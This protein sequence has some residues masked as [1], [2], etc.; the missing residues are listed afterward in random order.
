ML[1][2]IYAELEYMTS[3][4]RLSFVDELNEVFG[5]ESVGWRINATGHLDRQLPKIASAQEEAVFKELQTPRFSSGLAHLICSRQAYNARPRRDREV[6][7][8][9]FDA[10][11]SVAKEVLSLPTG[12]FG[13][14]IKTARSR[15]LLSSETLSILEKI[16]AL[17]SNHF[18]H[19]MTTP[20]ALKGPEVEFVY[21]SCIGGMLMFVRLA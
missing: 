2:G 14:A 7:S 5:E 17:R 8:E 15:S 3:G 9:A 13:D 4:L 18:G 16:Y 1:E 19:G 21:L 20:F 6:C 10:L 11:E 12:T